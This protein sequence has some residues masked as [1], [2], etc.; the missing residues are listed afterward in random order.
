MLLLLLSF[1]MSLE[2]ISADLLETEK[3][4]KIRRSIRTQRESL[5]VY[6]HRDLLIDTIAANSVTIVKGETGCGKSTQ[7]SSP[8]SLTIEIAVYY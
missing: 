2:A 1:Q 4:R 5:P 3:K 7:V 8:L 6:Q